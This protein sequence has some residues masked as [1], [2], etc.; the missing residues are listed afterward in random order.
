MHPLTIGVLGAGFAAA[1]LYFLENPPWEWESE[2]RRNV[3]MSPDWDEA[4]ERLQQAHAYHLRGGDGHARLR[5]LEA[6]H[7]AER[8]PEAQ[9][10]VVIEKIVELAD[11]VGL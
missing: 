9:R 3:E 4:W 5:L 11:T 8:L 7:H 10:A 2:R 1:G 6:M